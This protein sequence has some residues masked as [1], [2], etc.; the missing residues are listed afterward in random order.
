M[1][2]AQ[3]FGLA[4]RN[5]RIEKGWSQE[6][7]SEESGVCTRNYVGML[8]AGRHMPSL[9]MLYGFASVFGMTPCEFLQRVDELLRAATGG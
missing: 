4:L 5:L 7:L 2:L 1:T 6:T 9:K 8:E 3:A